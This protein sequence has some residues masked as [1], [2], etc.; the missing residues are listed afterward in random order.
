MCDALHLNSIKQTPTPL[1]TLFF[2]EFNANLLQRAI[3][4]SFKDKTGVAID[5]QSADDLY[6]IMRV[7][8]INNAGD[9]HKEINEQVKLMNSIVIKTAMS[10]IQSG[11]S[12][13]MGYMRDIDTLAVPPTAPQNTSTY[14]LKMDKSDKIGV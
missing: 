3:R 2:S 6:G 10:Q 13:F 1:N 14:G 5:Y 4:Q 9:Q 11:V 12:Q 8:F 7:V